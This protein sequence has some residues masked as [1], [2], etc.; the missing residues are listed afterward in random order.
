VSNFFGEI[1]KN[2]MTDFQRLRRNVLREIHDH[3]A[4]HRMLFCYE[5]MELSAAEI[6]DS[7][8]VATPRGSAGPQFRKLETLASR[9]CHCDH[10]KPLFPAKWIISELPVTR[11]Q[12]T[13][14]DSR[15]IEESLKWSE[16]TPVPHLPT[17]R[18]LE[19]KC[20]S[21]IHSRRAAG[22][23]ERCA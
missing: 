22:G 11:P 9:L 12:L 4:P 21:W 18:L 15:A 7:L 5:K 1:K 14:T 6:W 16:G 17:N 2:R 23:N 8:L 10:F 3:S 19:S 13:K 20:F